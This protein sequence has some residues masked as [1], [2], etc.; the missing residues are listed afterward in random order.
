MKYRFMRFP[1]GKP[2]A[3]TFSYDDGYKTDLRLADIF[4]KYGMKATFNITTKSIL[5]GS[6]KG[7]TIEEI[8]DLMNRGYE[9]ANHGAN[10]KAIGITDR[11]VG[12]KDILDCRLELE[13]MLGGIIRGYAYPD[14][15]RNI[16][17][18]NYPRIKAILE[19]L[20]LTYAR[21][22]GKDSDVFDL[23]EDFYSWYPNAHHDNPEVLNYVDKFVALDLNNVYIASRH[24]RLFFVWGHSSEFEQ[25]GNWDRIE[26]ISEKLSGK[27]EI[28]YATCQM[29]CE[30]T[31]AY[32]SLVFSADELTV[33]NPTLID[34]WFSDGN[35]DFKVASGQTVRIEE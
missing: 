8:K 15:M 25:K 1:E 11:I 10:H 34:L 21:L 30:Y 26:S 33:Y 20:G 5:S 28:W 22:C 31:K 14:T 6:E 2:K 3:V 7:C 24:P 13:E 29:I 32:N 23:P 27:S 4:E 16:K 17:G 35:R 12:I 19:D 18:D 9:I